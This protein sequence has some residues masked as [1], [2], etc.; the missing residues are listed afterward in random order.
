MADILLIVAGILSSVHVYTY[1]RWLKQHGNISGAILAFAV[2]ATTA[3]L[4][5]FHYYR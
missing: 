1:G 5:I 2:A 4:P 3:I